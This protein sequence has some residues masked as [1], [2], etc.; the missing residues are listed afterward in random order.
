MI[1]LKK[2]TRTAKNMRQMGENGNRLV[3]R[4]WSTYSWL[5]GNNNSFDK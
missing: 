4:G 3:T 2:Y 1:L 5:N